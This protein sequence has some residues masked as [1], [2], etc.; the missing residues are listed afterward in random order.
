MRCR[1]S[2]SNCTSG[3]DAYGVCLAPVITLGDVTSEQTSLL[4]ATSGVL[5]TSVAPVSTAAT[6]ISSMS[7]RA[8]TTE[9]SGAMTTSAT[10]TAVPSSLADYTV[11]TMA[12]T[13]PPTITSTIATSTLPT[14]SSE[15]STL[16]TQPPVVQHV[17]P[18][19]PPRAC[20]PSSACSGHGIAAAH[21]CLCYAQWTGAQCSVLQPP[22]NCVLCAVRS[23]VSHWNV[24]FTC[25]RVLIPAYRA[26]SVNGLGGF[27]IPLPYF[28]EVW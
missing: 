2:C 24:C 17:P 23:C 12:I 20:V 21:G 3:T 14:T 26:D 16:T 10:F 18:P 9:L 15:S 27:S 7:S 1:G 5:E 19:E 22:L 25:V 13:V 8:S 28:T 4:P 6:E 11:S